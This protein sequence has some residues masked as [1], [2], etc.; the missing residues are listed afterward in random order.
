MPERRFPPPWSVEETEAC[1]IV[2][3]ANRQALAYFSLGVVEK[4]TIDQTVMSMVAGIYQ[5][6]TPEALA[7]RKAQ[8]PIGFRASEETK[9]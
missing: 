5:S 6:F 8:E 3:D 4:A 7:S 2:R 9:S 1:F